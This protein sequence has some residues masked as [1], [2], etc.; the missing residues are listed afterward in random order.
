M[1]KRA[2]NRAPSPRDF[3]WSEHQRTCGGTYTKV[4]EPEG[5]GEKKAVGRKEGAG[6]GGGL[7]SA[8]GKDRATG[9][10][11]IKDMLTRQGGG[12]EKATL[13]GQ[14]VPKSSTGS[15]IASKVDL[16]VGEGHR[17][18]GSAP[19]AKPASLS[20]RR[21]KLLAAAE[22]REESTQQRGLKR[23]ATGTGCQDVRPFII[24]PAK[25]PR[26]TSQSDTDV[27]ILENGSDTHKAHSTQSS[28]GT[29]Q[30]TG[31]D[32]SPSGGRRARSPVINL[33]DEEEVSAPVR[34]CPV[35]GLT[36]IPAA[37]I[38]IHVAYCLD[39]VGDQSSSLIMS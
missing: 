31:Q 24:S 5:Y 35:C 28:V 39:E 15:A 12:E 25:R 6:S 1:V 23:K 22:K 32:S 27:I 10:R 4:K 20:E 7:S 11:D 30:G 14:N 18:S 33:V 36:D 38:N 16:F 21:Q 29:T 37:I 34:M 9:C 17:L 2:T 13:T 19:S 8:K 26:T 3:W